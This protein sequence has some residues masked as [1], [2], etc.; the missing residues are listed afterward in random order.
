MYAFVWD[1]TGLSQQ[2]LE[3]QLFIQHNF[4]KGLKEGLEGLSHWVVWIQ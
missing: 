4:I 2:A 1:G 3:H